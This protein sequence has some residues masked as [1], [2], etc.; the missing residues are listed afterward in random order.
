MVRILPQAQMPVYAIK[1]ELRQADLEK[2]EMELIGLPGRLVIPSSSKFGG[3]LR[4]AI[5]AG[6]VTEPKA[7]KITVEEDGVKRFEYR[8]NG[9]VVDDMHPAIVWKIGK[10]I[11]EIYEGITEIDPN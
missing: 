2:F 3:Y 5:G 10:E 4:A 11:A 6:W 8:F 9:S 7:S 1:E